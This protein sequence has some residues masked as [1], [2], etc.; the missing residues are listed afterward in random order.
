MSCHW[1]HDGNTCSKLVWM[2][3]WCRQSQTGKLHPAYKPA[4]LHSQFACWDK[5][6]CAAVSNR[7]ASFVCISTFAASVAALL[8]GSVKGQGRQTGVDKW[9]HHCSAICPSF[10]S[11]RPICCPPTPAPLFPP[12]T[13]LS[14][15]HSIQH[16]M[17]HASPRCIKAMQRFCCTVRVKLHKGKTA[18]S[19]LQVLVASHYLLAGAGW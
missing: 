16:A 19:I 14:P 2:V 1:P 9:H 5:H 11:T 4:C 7:S 8:A 15:W 6:G 18:L 13:S 17:Q 10:P 12:P 3:A